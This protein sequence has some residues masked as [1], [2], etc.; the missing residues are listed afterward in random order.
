MERENPYLIPVA[1]LIGSLVLAL[2][3]YTVRTTHLLGA[4]Q[5]NIDNLLPV[6]ADDHI[7]GN[8]S[9]RLVIIEYSDIDCEYCKQFQATLSELIREYGASGEVAWVYRHFPNVSVRSASGKHAEASECV[10][11]QGGTDAFF[12]FIDALNQQAPGASQFPANEYTSVVQK[13]GLS[14][15]AFTECLTSGEMVS[16]VSRDL[17]NAFAIGA[18]GA[19][20]SVLVVEGKDPIV[21]SGAVPYSALRQAVEAALAP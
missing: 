14:T 2:T 11:K 21:I 3:I 7:V 6:S 1:I 17:E 19:P 5:G 10:A 13:L 15:N 12:L 9:A 16:R 18:T 4:P 8:P 20:Y